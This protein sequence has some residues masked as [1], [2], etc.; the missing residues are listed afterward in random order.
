MFSRRVFGPTDTVF[1]LLFLGIVS[2]PQ[3]YAQITAILLAN[4]VS[5][6]AATARHPPSGDTA[7]L[8]QDETRLLVILA[9][10]PDNLGAL[11][12]M[13]WVRSRQQNYLAAVSYLE[14]ATQKHP[15][16]HAL[17]VA[18]D[19]DRFRFIEAEADYALST[20][21]LSSARKFYTLAI[22]IRPHCREA[23]AGLRS[24]FLRQQ[25]S[26]AAGKGNQPDR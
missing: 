12:G 4:A 24:T 26:F 6:A 9:R 7:Q 18:L 1:T 17:S 25:Q 23:S 19:L 8:K 11:A 10:D 15:D 14:S 13:A 3:S 2:W 21:D 22:Q 16:D 20:G 5:P